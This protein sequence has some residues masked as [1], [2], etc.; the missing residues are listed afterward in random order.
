MVWLHEN[1]FHDAAYLHIMLECDGCH[2]ILTNDE[3]E[4]Q[5]TYPDRNWEIALGDAARE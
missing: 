2:Q 5:P 3:L 1:P 4:G